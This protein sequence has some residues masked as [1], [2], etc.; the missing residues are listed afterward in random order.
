MAKVE[1]NE[2]KIEY[3]MCGEQGEY[4]TTV[5]AIGDQRYCSLDLSLLDH[6]M[7][8]SVWSLDLTPG[9][10]YLKARRMNL[11]NSGQ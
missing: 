5:T 2:S 6:V 3:D 9:L 4:H 8:G 7:I 1:Y 10:R 11:D